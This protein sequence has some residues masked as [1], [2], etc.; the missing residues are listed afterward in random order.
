MKKCCFIISYFGKLPNYFQ[1][2]LRTCAFNPD[3]NWLVF[4]DDTTPYQY[5]PNVK[6]V[7][8]TFDELR[9]LAN[10]KFDF[11]IYLEKPYK[12]CDYKP[13]FGY[14]YEDYIRDYMFWGHC[15]VDTLMGNLGTFLTDDLLACYDKIFCLGHLTLYKNTKE[16]NRVFMSKYKGRLLYKEVFQSPNI[17]VFDEEWKDEYNVNQIFLSQGKKVYMKDLSLNFSIFYLPFRKTTYTGN[18]KHDNH[19]YKIENF[20]KAIYLWDK[21]NIIRFIVDKG[22]V[23]KDYYLYMHLQQRKMSFNYSLGFVD[24]VQVLPNSFLYPSF[25]EVTKSDI[26]TTP[27][28]VNSLEMK[29]LYKEK[30]KKMIIRRWICFKI[31]LKKF[32]S[33]KKNKK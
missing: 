28:F 33:L 3:F 26:L 17:E 7:Y 15:D 2:F 29:M 24:R 31:K 19:G 4:T 25:S 21:G 27:K 9:K 10:S 23:R 18:V 5:P 8:Q 32:A 1:L 14:I 30:K 6:W 16:N 22:K 12:L 20:K 13:A 11:D